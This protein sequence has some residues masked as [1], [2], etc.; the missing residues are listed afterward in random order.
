MLLDLTGFND[1]GRDELYLL[2]DYGDWGSS[3]IETFGFVMDMD[4][5]SHVHCIMG[6]H[7]QMFLDQII[8]GESDDEQDMNWLYNNNGYITWRGYLGLKE[9]NKKALFDWLSGL[10]YSFDVEAGGRLY[11]AAHAY[12]YFGNRGSLFR[13]YSKDNAV[14]KRM[15]WNEDPFRYY[16]GRKQYEALICGH[17]ITRHFLN[18]KWDASAGNDEKENSIFVGPHFIDIDCGAKCF[19]Y[20]GQ[21]PKEARR[22]RLAAIR[23]D[24]MKQFYLKKTSEEV[25]E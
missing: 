20:S 7:D 10:K 2:G 23:L 14:W 9:K 19:D 22:A 18:K 21:L 3:S 17:T 12:P 11:M 8:A 5:S 13:H 24:D 1:D 4:R 25:S 15:S 16:H 6:N